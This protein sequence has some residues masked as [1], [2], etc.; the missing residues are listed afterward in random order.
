VDAPLEV[1]PMFVRAGAI[2]P[3][4]EPLQHS[5]DSASVA[6]E[7]H[8]YPRS[9][10]FTLYEDDGKSLEYQRGAFCESEYRQEIKAEDV[11]S[12]HCSARRGA[13]RPKNGKR[14]VVIHGV[15]GQTKPFILP[16][17]GNDWS[18]EIPLK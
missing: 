3:M 13:Y 5:G 12:I 10:H 2:L 9:G 7:L 14:V 18:L 16:E 11:W 6:L 4:W 1:M 17:D 8:F 15:P